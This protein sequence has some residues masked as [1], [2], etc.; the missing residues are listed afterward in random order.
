MLPSHLNLAQFPKSQRKNNRIELRGRYLLVP[1]FPYR[2]LCAQSTYPPYGTR[3]DTRVSPRPHPVD[4]TC[5]S[6]EPRLLD[7][8]SGL[9]SVG[10]D[11]LANWSPVL[12]IRCT[13]VP[14]VPLDVFWELC[15][16]PIWA[17][18]VS[19]C[20]LSENRHKQTILHLTYILSVGIRHPV[21]LQPIVFQ[22]S[23][24]PLLYGN[25]INA[26]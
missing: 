5:A 3:E 10:Q 12:I 24:L 9:R 18:G 6:P 1:P 14:R 19:S 2:E 8:G 15:L 25:V 4:E 17:R 20:L 13:A 22:F 16:P 23:I 21:I 26:Y 11:Y 7:N